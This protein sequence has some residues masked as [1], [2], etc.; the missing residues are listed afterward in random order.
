GDIRP[1]AD[2]EARQDLSGPALHVV[3]WADAAPEAPPVRMPSLE[4][5]ADVLRRGA[6]QEQV[7]NLE[8]AGQ[9]HAR[10]PVDRRARDALTEQEY[11]AFAGPKLTG[12]QAK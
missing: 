9:T 8:R 12:D 11:V 10:P 2:P 7:R 1:V 4:G 6:V 3:T 5:D